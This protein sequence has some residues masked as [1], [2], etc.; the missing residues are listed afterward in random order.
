MKMVLANFSNQQ[1]QNFDRPNV[2]YAHFHFRQLLLFLL[3]SHPLI[4]VGIMRHLIAVSLAAG[5]ITFWTYKCGQ[6]TLSVHKINGGFFPKNCI[7][8]FANLT[9]AV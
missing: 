6:N 7:E 8:Y 1:F 4:I 2:Y 3:H 5:V 9:S